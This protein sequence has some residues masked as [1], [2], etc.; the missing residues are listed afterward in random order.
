MSDIIE[1]CLALYGSLDYYVSYP[2][3]VVESEYWAEKR[4]P[5]GRIRDLASERTQRKDDLTYIA[6]AINARPPGRVV[7]V[8]CGLGELLEQVDDAHERIGIDPSERAVAVAA[9]H[10]GARTIQGELSADLFSPA[11]CDVIVAHHVIEH[12]DAPVTFV[13]AV[14]SLLRPG[15][16]FIV[17]TPNFASAAARLFGDRFRLLHDPTHV[18]LFSDDSLLRLLR[19]MGFQIKAVEYPFFE[20]RFATQD[21]WERMLKSRDGVSPAF[22]GSFVTVFAEKAT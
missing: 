5:D 12:M 13:R 19:D 14:A 7:D 3:R 4:D 6:N 8:G 21:A 20:T 2:A 9:E 10:S 22:W 18:S 1:R 11:S 16:L 17:G 15:G